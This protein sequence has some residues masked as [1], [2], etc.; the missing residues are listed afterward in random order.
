MYSILHN[1]PRIVH[2][3]DRY[4]YPSLLFSTPTSLVIS[5]SRGSREQKKDN[6]DRDSG[7]RWAR[8][9]HNWLLG[10]QTAKTRV[11]EVTQ[12]QPDTCTHSSS[13]A[14]AP[15]EAPPP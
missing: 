6:R 14:S 1:I 11:S 13:S 7:Q 8:D 3:I 4:A 9:A 15:K 10:V 2:C 5:F 12:H